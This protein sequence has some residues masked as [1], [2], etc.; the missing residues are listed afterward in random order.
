VEH[1][2]ALVRDPWVVIAT[3]MLFLL[4]LELSLWL[5]SRRRFSNHDVWLERLTLIVDNL[6]KDR[7]AARVQSLQIPRGTHAEP[8]PLPT[9]TM[10]GASWSDDLDL[11]SVSVHDR[12]TVKYP[13]PQPKPPPKRE[14]E[15]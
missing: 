8:P 5:L 13:I 2:D 3:I 10:G 14:P 1:I 7:A 4:L 6:H 9:T 11:T 12:P 15:T